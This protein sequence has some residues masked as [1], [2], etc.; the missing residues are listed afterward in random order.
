MMQ[1]K[2]SVVVPV[3][4]E[5]DSV[6]PLA[7]SIRKTMAILNEP[8]EIIFVNDGSTDKTPEWLEKLKESSVNLRVATLNK[9]SGQTASLK[10]GFDMAKG[11][12]IISMDGDMQNDPADIPGLLGKMREGYDVV[13]GWRKKRHDSLWKKAASKSANIIQNIVFKSHLHDIACTLRA[14]RK[15]ALNGVDLSW[16]GAHRFIPYLLLKHDS[17]IAEV[18]VRHHPRMYGKS[19]YKPTKIFKTMKDFLKLIILRKI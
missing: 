3:Y 4:N 13:C 8:Y 10:A 19:K 7:E 6:M 14:Y 16:N 9:N 15:G 1:V 17:R 12:F 2:Y 11:E 5:E 18:E